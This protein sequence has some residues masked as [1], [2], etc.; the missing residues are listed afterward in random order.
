MLDAQFYRPVTTPRTDL[1]S[2]TG[3]DDTETLNDVAAFPEA[4]DEAAAKLQDKAALDA[5]EALARE[6]Q[7]E[8][9]EIAQEQNEA[10]PVTV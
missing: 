2:V 3:F 5:D 9:E 4:S 10:H 6:L 1:E 7:Q 8:F